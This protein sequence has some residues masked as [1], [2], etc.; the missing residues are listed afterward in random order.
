MVEKIFGIAS[1]VA[2]DAAAAATA[3]EGEAAQ[4]SMV[5][6]LATT[7]LPLILIFVVFWFMLIRP[8]RKKDKQ[9]KEMLNNLK[10]GDRI[11]TI[12]GIYG[13]ITGLKDDTVTLSVGKDNL[14]MVVARWAIRSV[15]EVS[16]ENDAQELN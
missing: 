7:F 2:E 4:G 15:E 6:A 16:I 8:Q 1:A 5:A 12:G 3:A 10:A 9:V 11:C 14:S 13:T